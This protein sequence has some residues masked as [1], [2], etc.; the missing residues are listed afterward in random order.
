MIGP[1]ELIIVG[2]WILK[3][4]QMLADANCE[5]IHSL[6]TTHLVRIDASPHSGGWET[7]YR[8]PSDGRYWE[9]VYPQGEVHGGGPPTLRVIEAEAAGRKYRLAG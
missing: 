7:L 9:R 8:D 1:D 5:R 6:V 4:G 3:D 2:R